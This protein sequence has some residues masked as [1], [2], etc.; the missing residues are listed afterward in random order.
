MLPRFLYALVVMIATLNRPSAVLLVALFGL[1]AWQTGRLRREWRWLLLY[2]LLWAVTFALIQ[3]QQG[4]GGYYWTRERIWAR[5]LETI[6]DAAL[7]VGLLLGVWWLWAAR[8]LRQAQGYWRAVALAL[9]LYG[10]MIAL[11]GIWRE[12]RLLVPMLPLLLA[13]GLVRRG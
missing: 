12:T 5:N 3:L 2:A 11:F 6:P 10:G 9:V 4:T 7:H 1:C 13:I 8:G